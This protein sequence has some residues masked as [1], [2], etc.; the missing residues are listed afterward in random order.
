MTAL[1]REK[2]G[3]LAVKV[4]VKCGFLMGR[5]YSREIAANALVFSS[6]QAAAGENPGNGLIPTHLATAATSTAAVASSD[7]SPSNNSRVL[8]GGCDRS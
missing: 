6:V 5:V 4:P 1:Q 2:H 7:G 3:C 8:A